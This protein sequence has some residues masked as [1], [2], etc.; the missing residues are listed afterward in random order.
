MGGDLVDVVDP[1][2]DVVHLSAAGELPA[3]GLADHLVV[4][5]HDV[6]L[7]GQAVHRRLL[8]NAHIPD[9]HQAHVECPGNGGG[10]Q[11]QNVHIFL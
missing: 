5:L 3:D 4:V 9:A 8:Q 2:V 11:R 10:R 6:G 7:D 1:V